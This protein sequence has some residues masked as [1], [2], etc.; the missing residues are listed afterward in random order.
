MASPDVLD[1]ETLL[2]PI[3]GDRPTGVDIRSDW[4]PTSIYQS[5]KEARREARDA[6]RYLLKNPEEG[7]QRYPGGPNWG[8]VLR[9]GPKILAE[10][11]KDLE[12]TAWLIEA[13]VRKHGFAGLLD[14]YRLARELVERYWEGLY[15]LP[16][17]EDGIGARVAALTGLNGDDAEGTL[18][19]PI[20]SIP[21]T[22]MGSYSALSLWQ[23]EQAAALEALDD[24]DRRAQRIAQGDVT[25]PMFE[26]AVSETSHEF[27]RNLLD[28]IEAAEN[29]F[30]KLGEKL[31]ELCGA[32]AAP[33]TSNIRNALSQT[34][35]VVS[36]ITKNLFADDIEATGEG[37]DAVGVEGEAGASG[38][39]RKITAREDAFRTLL[40]VA[41]FFRRTEPHAPISYLLEQAV[42]WGKMPLPELLTE[43]IPDESARDHLFRLVGIKPPENPQ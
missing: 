39:G 8:E 1:F 17:A 3:P 11:T 22:E 24:P 13:I 43:L 31:D 34:H 30:G 6:E 27:F 12:I 14:G 29:E 23:Y 20:R 16:D 18:V 42:R 7:A 40:Q 28:D 9:L 26:R 36:N 2:A 19:A 10:N 37:A 4:S 21:I 32:R 41:D 15:P 33:P 38:G 25:L 35:E 5:I